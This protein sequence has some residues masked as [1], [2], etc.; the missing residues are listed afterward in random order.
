MNKTL[1]AIALCLGVLVLAACTT[2]E[3]PTPNNSI[4]GIVWEWESETVNPA[5]ETTTV[6]NPKK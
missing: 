4:A 1:V 6:P 5:N 3:E 2:E